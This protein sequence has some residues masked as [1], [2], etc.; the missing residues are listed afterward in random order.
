MGQLDPVYLRA[1]QGRGLGHL[2]MQCR[3]C[4]KAGRRTVLNEPPHDATQRHV[5][6][7]G[8]YNASAM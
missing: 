4:E 8:P 7:G 1:R 3:E 6:L 2:R 5:R